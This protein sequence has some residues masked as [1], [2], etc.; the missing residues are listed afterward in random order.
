ML[1]KVQDLIVYQ[2]LCEVHLKICSIIRGWPVEEKHELAGQIG[3]CLNSSPAQLAEKHNNR[4]VRN[5][6]EGVN[7]SRDEANET[8]HYLSVASLKGYVTAS[9]FDAIRSEYEECIRMLNGLER[10]LERQLPRSHRHWP[11][12]GVL[13]AEP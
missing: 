8:I 9:Q 11:E 3:R 6:I 10:K 1:L 7:G 13:R 2:R 12:S 5:K 4:H